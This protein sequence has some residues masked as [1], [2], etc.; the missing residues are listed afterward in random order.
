MSAE[1]PSTEEASLEGWEP[2]VGLE[3]SLDEVVE[4]AF[5]YRGDVTVAR[6]DGTELVGYL[7]NRNAEVPDPFVQ[8]FDRAGDGPFTIRYAEIRTIRFTGKDPAAG[9]SY[10]AWLRRKAERPAAAASGAAYGA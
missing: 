5:D 2:A 4:L 9:K 7:F 1:P 8:V 10:E 6:Q 3:V